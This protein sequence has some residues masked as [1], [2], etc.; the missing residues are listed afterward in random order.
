[1]PCLKN[2]YEYACHV[3]L[4]SCSPTGLNTHIDIHKLLLFF[5]RQVVKVHQNTVD[6]YLEDVIM[7]AIDSTASDQARQE[8]QQLA[9]HVNEA[10]YAAERK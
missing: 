1:V 9:V 2:A 10:A 5:D 3:L 4:L 8:I 6:A 7:S